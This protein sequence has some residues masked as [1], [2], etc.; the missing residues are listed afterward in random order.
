MLKS[1][2]IGIGFIVAT[3]ILWV[4][5]QILWKKVFKDEYKEEDVL[6]G[7]RNCSNCGCTNI[8][9]RKE[10]ANLNPETY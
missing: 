3:A 2:I 5:V 10:E 7:R 9:K 8:C 1:L 6:E 4:V